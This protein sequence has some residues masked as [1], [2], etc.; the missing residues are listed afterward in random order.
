MGIK[1]NVKKNISKKITALKNKCRVCGWELFDTPL[2]EYDNMPMVAQYLPDKDLLKNDKGI[3][4]RVYQCSGCGLVQLNSEPVSYYKEVIRATGFSAEMKGF[5]I[6]QFKDF[7]EKYP[8]KYKKVIEIGC[9][10]GEYLSIIQGCGV[11]SYGIEYSDDLVKK[12]IKEGLNVSREFIENTGYKIKNYPFDAF[13]IMS[14]LEHLPDPNQILRGIYNN[15]VDGA[16]GIVEVPNFDMILRNNLFSEFMRDH[17]SYFTKETLTTV[18]NLNGFEVIECNEIWHDYIISAVVRKRKKIDLSSFHKNQV[19]LKN[20][21][22]D[23]ISRFGSKRVAI[24]GAGHQSFAI[25][26]LFGLGEKIR[27]IVDSAPFKQGKF[28]PATH[29]LIVSPEKLNIDPVDAIIVIAGSYSNE[30][31]KILREEYNKK[32]KVSILKDFG[33]EII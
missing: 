19:K 22:E 13:F 8:L 16:V 15:L 3:D 26:S 17:L 1:I 6:K 2:L 4:L 20:E 29:S 10:G 32:I 18:L 28:T 30:V 12:C 27:Y 25:L 23:F 24:W 21:I 11:K 5:R 33:L 31:A 7:V 14:F 9:G